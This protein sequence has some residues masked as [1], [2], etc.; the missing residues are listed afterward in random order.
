MTSIRSWQQGKSQRWFLVWLWPALCCC[1]AG[2]SGVTVP[3][4]LSL[5]SPVGFLTRHSP[6]EPRGIF[7]WPGSCCSAP[8]LHRFLGNPTRG[9]VERCLSIFW[10]GFDPKQGNCNA[11]SALCLTLRGL[12]MCHKRPEHGNLTLNPKQAATGRSADRRA[13]SDA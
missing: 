7:N 4:G 8:R 11:C 9:V 10:A 6:H 12:E 5:M 3:K 13:Q 1:V 2:D